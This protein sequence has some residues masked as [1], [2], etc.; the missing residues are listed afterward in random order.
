METKI[1][2]YGYSS[3]TTPSSTF[4]YDMRSREKTLVKQEEVLGGFDPADYLEHIAEHVE[5]W[6]YIKFPFLKNV[7]WK[8]F[9]DGNDSG[10]YAATPLSRLNAADG[11][12]VWRFLAAAGDLISTGPTGT[13]VNDLVVG[14]RA[15]AG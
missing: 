6:S 15:D 7:G 13:N 12:F 14:L 4:E 11:S 9:V 5:P 3:L 10:V 8:G 1:L 2:R